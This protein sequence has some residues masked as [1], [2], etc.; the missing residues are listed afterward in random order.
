MK[1]KSA[2]LFFKLKDKVENY[3]NASIRDEESLITRNRGK[4]N[5]FKKEKYISM[6]ILVWRQYQS[7][8]TQNMQK[9]HFNYDSEE[10]LKYCCLLF[11]GKSSCEMEQLA[12]FCVESAC[13]PCRCVG[14]LQ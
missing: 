11:I 10:F 6:K 3:Q 14:F 7:A 1:Q 9:L 4:K 13:S 12:L 5:T 8:V 2:I